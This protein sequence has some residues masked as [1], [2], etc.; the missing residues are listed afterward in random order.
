[1]SNHVFL[2]T[3]ASG[4][5]GTQLV[6]RL[7]DTD[8]TVIAMSYKLNTNV[9][10]ECKN[11]TYIETD[12][13]DILFLSKII[14]SVDT[15]IHLAGRAHQSNEESISS[16]P[17]YFEAN[18]SPLTSL[19]NAIPSNHA[20][21]IVFLSTIAV[22]GKS[23]G[24]IHLDDP[25]VPSSAYGLSKFL[26]E[27]CLINSTN[28][29]LSYTILRSPLIFGESAPGNLRRLFLLSK[30]SPLLPF[31]SLTN[32]KSIV[33]INTLINIILSCSFEPITDNKIYLIAD[34]ISI[35]TADILKYFLIVQRRPLLI[36]FYFPFSL[37]RTLFTLF[38]QKSLFLK[39]SN[40][41]ELDTS[42]L[43]ADLPYL[44]ASSSKTSRDLFNSIIN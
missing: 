28:H 15:I 33:I 25:I 29:H 10:Y 40:Q 32:K 13:K 39:L 2:V 27:R 36:L 18:V 44:S 24:L 6:K 22:Y 34:S 5:V 9:I 38:G 1:M 42:K 14:A 31:K 11:Y 7:I 37:L 43:Y 23:E 30:F 8:F 21:K 4:F 12:Y 3:G 19:I 41:L 17:L 35:S 20:V 16:Y 26:A